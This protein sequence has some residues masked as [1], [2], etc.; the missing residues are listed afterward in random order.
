ME[1]A[2]I[3]TES[4]LKGHSHLHIHV[5]CS[6]L[7]GEDKE[8]HRCED[9]AVQRKR[10]KEA[11]RGATRSHGIFQ[12]WS[13]TFHIRLPWYLSTMVLHIS[14]QRAHSCEPHPYSGITSPG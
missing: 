13:Y 5:S 12:P 8:S 2:F 3:S 10:A 11:V 1:T 9:P 7:D 14:Y 6:D 4:T